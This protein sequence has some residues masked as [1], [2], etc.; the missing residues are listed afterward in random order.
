M[1]LGMSRADADDFGLRGTNEGS[2]LAGNKALW[3]D[4]NLKS[5]IE[6]G[7]SEFI[8][9]PGGN[10]QG[11]TS[12]SIGYLGQWWTAFEYSNNP[13]SAWRRSVFDT[14]NYISSNADWKRI[15]YSVRC[16]RD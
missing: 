8:A 1:V 12:S 11:G 10:C 3:S 15:D 16:G 4:G 7:S 13:I 14:N 6:F 9:L 5:I 2:K